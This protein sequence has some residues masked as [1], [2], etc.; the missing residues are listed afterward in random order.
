[1]W[2]YLQGRRKGFWSGPVVIGASH[3][4]STPMISS[5]GMARKAEY[6]CEYHQQASSIKGFNKL[7]TLPWTVLWGVCIFMQ[8]P[9]SNQ[10]RTITT[11]PVATAGVPRHETPYN[12]NTI[13]RAQSHCFCMDDN[14]NKQI[15]MPK[16]NSPTSL[17]QCWCLNDHVISIST[18]PVTQSRAK[19]D[20]CFC[21]SDHTKITSNLPADGSIVTV[22]QSLCCVD[23]SHIT[24]NFTTN[25]SMVNVSQC[26]CC[27]DK[28]NFTAEIEGNG[29]TFNISQS[30]CLSDK[31]QTTTYLTAA[32]R[33]AVE[34]SQWWCLSD[35]Y[36]NTVSRPP[37]S[38]HTTLNL[39]P[40]MCLSDP[41]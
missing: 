25:D 11:Q 34:L 22:K 3:T 40:R 6:H 31:S 29:S 9:Q 18:Q 14:V 20:Q 19:L 13:R 28:S 10:G 12:P 27:A 41:G 24:I 39:M 35:K 2:F 8:G 15:H 16:G 17:S 5:R 4:A 32:T 38:N 26:I 37:D 21:L 23:K 7:I 1:M 33:S 36:K 30:W